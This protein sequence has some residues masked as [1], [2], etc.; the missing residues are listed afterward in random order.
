M[1]G[2]QRGVAWCDVESE[3]PE[4]ASDAEVDPIE[5]APGPWVQIVEEAPFEGSPK[6]EACGPPAQGLIQASD[7]PA[8]C[9]RHLRRDD[10]PPHVG[11][12]KLSSKAL[13]M[14]NYLPSSPAT[15]GFCTV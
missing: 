15:L 10:P 12:L 14:T 4:A 5:E 2:L 3:D 6:R 13:W 7:K 11:I 9:L 1:P 8:S